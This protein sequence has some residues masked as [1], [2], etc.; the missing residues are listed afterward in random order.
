MIPDV[1]VCKAL[2][3]KITNR[4]RRE[5]QN[6]RKNSTKG[7]EPEQ[8]GKELF[9]AVKREHSHETVTKETAMKK[10]LEDCNNQKM[11]TGSRVLSAALSVA[12]AAAVVITSTG[13]RSSAHSSSAPADPAESNVSAQTS[14]GAFPVAVPADSTAQSSTA[15]TEAAAA[16]DTTDNKDTAAQSG[17]ASTAAEAAAAD[18]TAADPAAANTAGT[19]ENREIYDVPAD[20]PENTGAGGTSAAS[21]IESAPARDKADTA[22]L[23]SVLSEALV[24]CTGW[25]QSAGSSLRAASAATRLLRWANQAKAGSADTAALQEAAAAELGRLSAN[26]RSSIKDN[27]SFIS[28][29]ADTILDDIEELK[30]VLEDAGCLETAKDA[31]ADE[32]ARSNWKAASEAI[33]AALR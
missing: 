27:W 5:N 33:E 25:G 23:E 9:R 26:Q 24:D 31:A 15:A 13:C 30:N 20:A 16:A 8:K 14:A 3:R 21:V 4:N 7:K 19:T 18:S 2:Y 1:C 29:D 6:R 11:K 12:V 28:Y 22:L 17:T 10:K 32:N